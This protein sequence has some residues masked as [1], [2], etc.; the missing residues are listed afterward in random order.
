MSSFRDQPPHPELALKRP[1]RG[2]LA[3]LAA[4]R[5]AGTALPPELLEAIRAV[6]TPF[7]KSLQVIKLTICFK[8]VF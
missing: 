8:N 7:D 6:P 5:R 1:A 3:H 2:R 4:L